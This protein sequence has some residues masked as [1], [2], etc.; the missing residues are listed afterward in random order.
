MEFYS[1]I[2]YR[3]R[4]S[5]KR[6]QGFTKA[7][8]PCGHKARSHK[9]DFCKLHE[10]QR[11]SRFINLEGRE[12]LEALRLFE[13]TY[14]TAIVEQGTSD[15]RPS[16]LSEYAYALRGKFLRTGSLIDRSAYRGTAWAVHDT[17][18]LPPRSYEQ[19]QR[20]RLAKNS[21][22]DLLEMERNPYTWE[23]DRATIRA[24]LAY[25]GIMPED[26]AALYC[27]SCDGFHHRGECRAPM[28]SITGTIDADGEK[29]HVWGEQV[30]AKS[31]GLACDIFLTYAQANHNGYCHRYRWHPRVTIIARNVQSGETVRIEP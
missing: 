1:D 31:A 27:R 10:G 5:D 22:A 13:A 19:I 18:H 29:F 12:K 8:K 2:P 14:Y 16:D 4:Q 28:W 26:Y 24:I 23:K 15:N 11:S 3:K 30:Q 6:C 17:R 25:R 20:Q 21:V 7:G 9:H